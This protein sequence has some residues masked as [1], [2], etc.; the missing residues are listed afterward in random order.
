MTIPLHIDPRRTALVI[1]DLQAFA[2]G[3]PCRPNAAA[4]VVSGAGALADVFRAGDALVVHVVASLGVGGGVAIARPPSADAPPF[5]FDLPAGWDAIP[6]ALGPDAAD[7]I[8]TKW[9]WDAFHGTDLD[10][11]L[12]R[13]GID[14][15]VLAGI[16][17]NIGVESTA[18]AAFERGYRQLFASDLLAA[19]SEAEHETTISSVLSRVGHLRTADE[20][21]A[22][23]R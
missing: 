23:L 16:S 13:R 19:F 21:A 12:R 17:T 22:L 8:V 9:G 3:L 4:E 18:R 10:V 15:I 7:V 11:Q 20:I 14:T 2:T 6:T 1:I 5:A